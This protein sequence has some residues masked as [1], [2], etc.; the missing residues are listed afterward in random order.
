VEKGE[1][2]NKDNIAVGVHF[3][4]A[5]LF[6]SLIFYYPG[7]TDMQM[8]GDGACLGRMADRPQDVT[9]VDAGGTG[10]ISVEL[11]MAVEGVQ[12]SAS[13]ADLRMSNI[14]GFSQKI[15][16]KMNWLAGEDGRDQHL[17]LNI[18]YSRF[19]ILHEV[20]INTFMG[21]ASWLCACAPPLEG[22]IEQHAGH[23]EKA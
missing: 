10:Q 22:I 12:D 17:R 13:P 7:A 8:R 6:C 20:Q 14:K 1:W 23:K 18:L 2:V 11:P 21:M 3:L 4:P 5:K 16:M 19:N 15:T 9:F